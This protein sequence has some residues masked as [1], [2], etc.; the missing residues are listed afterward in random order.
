[1]VVMQQLNAARAA[2][3]KAQDHSRAAELLDAKAHV[4]SLGS[5][6][7]SLRDRRDRD[8]ARGFVSL[9]TEKELSRVVSELHAAHAA[10]CG[11]LA[12]K[13][14]SE[15]PPNREVEEAEQHRSIADS[16]WFCACGE[17]TPT[18]PIAAK[19]VEFEDPPKYVRRRA[20][21]EDDTLRSS[22]PILNLLD[23]DVLPVKNSTPATPPRWQR[24]VGWLATAAACCCCVFFVVFFALSLTSAVDFSDASSKSSARSNTSSE[25]S[26]PTDQMSLWHKRGSPSKD[27]VWV[28]TELERCDV[29]GEDGSRAYESCA[30]CEP[31]LASIPTVKETPQPASVAP[32]A[33]LISPSA[34]T[35]SAAPSTT[36]S[37]VAPSLQS[38]SRR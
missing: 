10:L 27:C 37:T 29:E 11:R 22:A 32:T 20:A 16:L 19:T 30:A 38:S 3:I 18:D 36:T 13:S 8:K 33:V 7:R 12:D 28:S 4:R 6:I 24:P 35:E 17:A 2:A 25:S 31:R 34:V 15:E 9:E 21:C 5:R 23:D 1:M 14:T 26:S